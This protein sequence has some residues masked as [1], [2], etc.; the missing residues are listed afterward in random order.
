MLLKFL[1][2]LVSFFIYNNGYTQGLKLEDLGFKEQE[3]KPDP[4]LAN[5]LQERRFYLSQHNVWGIVAASTMLLAALSGG[6]GDLPPEHP[7]F[8]GLAAISYGA[9]AYT[10]YKA[11]EVPGEKHYGGSLW[12]RRLVWIHLPGMILAPILGYMAAQKIDKGEKLSGLEKHHRDIAGI[13]AGAL[14]LSALT[15]SFDF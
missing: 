1:I 2:I 10:A 4:K 11:P 15:V 14:I 12:H 5:I 3:T 7:Y 6:E 9:A 13:T 8:A